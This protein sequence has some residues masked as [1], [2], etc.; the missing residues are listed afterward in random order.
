M[1]AKVKDILRS[2][3]GLQPMCSLFSYW[4][5]PHREVLLHNMT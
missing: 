4:T 2:V 5:V 3:H 1:T